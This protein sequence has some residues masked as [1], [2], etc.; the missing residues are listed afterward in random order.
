MHPDTL[1]I[2]KACEDWLA[3]RDGRVEDTSYEG[4][5][6]ILRP[7]R[8]ELGQLG[9]QNL[10]RRDVDELDVGRARRA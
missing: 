1:T 6:W 9:V 4:Y 10:E 7:V 2:D 5:A 8:S 3:S